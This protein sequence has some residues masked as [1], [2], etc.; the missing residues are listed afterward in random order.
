VIVTTVDF[1]QTGVAETE[2]AQLHQ[3]LLDRLQRVPG[4]RSAASVFIPPI[5]DGGW[6]NETILVNG[7]CSAWRPT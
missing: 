6:W 2:Q 1:R 4:V 5:S 7:P 3:H